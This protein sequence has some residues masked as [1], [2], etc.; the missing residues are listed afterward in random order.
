MG[1][2]FQLY[3]V[4]PTNAAAHLVLATGLLPL[5]QDALFRALLS[6]LSRAAA[7]VVSLAAL[8]P[9][10]QDA[11]FHSVRVHFAAAAVLYDERPTR[12]WQLS[13]AVPYWQWMPGVKEHEQVAARTIHAYTSAGACNTY[14]LTGSFYNHESTPTYTDNF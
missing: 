6:L 2:W 4:L 12:H 8:S 14:M 7:A 3:Q 13:P 9:L 10:A 11:L 1:C 5:V